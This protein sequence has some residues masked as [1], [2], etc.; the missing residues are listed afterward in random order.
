MY[1]GPGGFQRTR[2]SALISIIIMFSSVFFMIDQPGVGLR[3]IGDPQTISGIWNHF[4]NVTSIG[5]LDQDGDIEL[6]I[7]LPD[8]PT[9]GPEAGTVYLFWGD[10]EGFSDLSPSNADIIFHG[11]NGDRFGASV[12]SWDVQGNGWEEIVIGCPGANTSSGKVLIFN[13][14]QVNDADAGTVYGPEWAYIELIGQSTNSFGGWMCKGNYT[15]SEYDDLAVLSSGNDTTEPQVHLFMGGGVPGLGVNMTLPALSVSPTTQ[16]VSLDLMGRGMDALIYSTPDRGMMRV[17]Y[18]GIEETLFLLPGANSTGVVDFQGSIQSSGNTY[19]WGAGDDGWDTSGSDVFDPPLIPNSLRFNQATGNARGHNRSIEN[20]SRLEIEMGGVSPSTSGSPESGAYGVSFQLSPS[21]LVGKNSALLSFDYIWEDWGFEDN[22]RMWIKGRITNGDGDSNWL[23]SNIDFNPAPDTTPEIWTLKGVNSGGS[24]IFMSGIGHYEEEVL[25]ILGPS[26]E[27]Y[28]ELGGKISRW[29]N[30]VECGAVGFD[31]ITLALRSLEMDITTMTGANGIGSTLMA[32]DIDGDG[33]LDLASGNPKQDKVR[34]YLGNDPYWDSF[35]AF[36]EE[37]ANM[38]ITGDTGSDFGRD[39]MVI[40][41]SPFTP[42]KGL[43]ISFPAWSDGSLNGT[44]AIVIFDLPMEEGEYTLDGGFLVHHDESEYAFGLK[45]ISLGDPDEDGYPDFMVILLDGSNRLMVKKYDR[46]PNYPELRLNSPPRGVP[47]SGTIEIKATMSDKDLDATP[48]DIMFYRS[49]DNRSWSPVGNGTPDKVEGQSA[50]KYWDTKTFEN[51]LYFLKVEV[52]D[53]FGLSLARYSNS[54]QVLNHRAPNIFLTY[55]ADGIEL[56]GNVEITARVFP[57]PQEYLAMP[58]RFLLSRDGENW[59]E[60]ANRSSTVPGS[61][62]DYS[63][64]L[65]TENLEDGEI[66]FKIN[67]STEFGLG[68]EE[69]NSEPCIIDNYYS[70]EIEFLGEYT[71]NLSGVINVSVR[72]YD[73]DL[74]L[75]PPV[76]LFIKDPDVLAW[77]LLGD[78]IGP[79]GNW[80]YYYNWDTTGVE[81]GEYD[82]M[83]RAMDMTF[84][85]AQEALSGHVRIHNPYTPTISIVNIEEGSILSGTP[86]IRIQI[87][88][89]DMNF[90]KTDV[91]LFYRDPDVGIWNRISP[92]LV[93]GANA[94]ADWDTTYLKNKGYDLRAEVTDRDNLSAYTEVLGVIVKN[95]IP[96]TVQGELFTSSGPIKGERRIFFNITDDEPISIENITVEV[97]VFSGWVEIVPVFRSDPEAVFVPGK[98]VSFYI[99]WN[100]LDEDEFGNPLFPDGPGY[101]IRITYTDPD[102]QSEVWRSVVSYSVSNRVTGGGS[103]PN[104][105]GSSIDPGLLAI[106][107]LIAVVVVVLLVVGLFIWRG[108]NSERKGSITDIEEIRPREVMEPPKEEEAPSYYQERKS[109]IYSPPG[110]GS[111]TSDEPAPVTAVPFYS[112]EDAGA[113]MSDVDEIDTSPGKKTDLLEDI[114]GEEKKAPPK[115]KQRKQREGLSL[116]VELPAGAMPSKAEDEPEDWAEA[117]EWD[118]EEEAWEEF[119]ELEDDDDEW[120]EEEEEDI[121]VVTCKCGNEI[122]ISS[123]GDGR[124][125]CN[126]CGRKGRVKL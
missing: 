20:V 42:M 22:E 60:F 116:E 68:A 46:G 6:V 3:D 75:D 126:E 124:F 27:H 105:D 15:G 106:M 59:T 2:A 36:N 1:T 83:A 23:G 91:K 70:P 119:E 43:F 49:I 102:A 80:T 61:D 88:D 33:S 110:W 103:G 79:I 34:I 73:K 87:I 55:P 99:D 9:Y 45:M 17:I 98:N 48:W 89:R 32:E 47:L 12:T 74:D 120:E 86:R 19:G 78:L 57:P 77:D 97:F 58:V 100:T 64:V 66:W 65:D 122:E 14:V 82:L 50:I 125:S 96:P 121:L 108:S 67:A 28:L 16:C 24:G 84:N 11:N 10:D 25:S 107:V 18:Y 52:T 81:N 93:I 30:T 109:E 94:T 21:D 13:Q 104:E 90:N 35:S 62:V 95:L 53:S 7:S 40:G 38:T 29:T 4:G 117:E 44:G 92:V 31:N 112:S 115:K 5:D 8:D 26:G 56:N 69:S 118:E 51:R 76:Q 101:E 37:K 41:T 71:G 85:E 113:F 123:S 63:T 114:F 39:L 111:E 54:I 72:A